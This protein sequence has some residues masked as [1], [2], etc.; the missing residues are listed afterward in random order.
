MDAASDRTPQPEGMIVVSH[1]SAKSSPLRTAWTWQAPPA[2]QQS[3]RQGQWG[4]PW[5]I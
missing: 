4:R 5:I 1:E 2:Q 3:V